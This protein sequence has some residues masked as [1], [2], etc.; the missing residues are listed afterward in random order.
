MCDSGS[1]RPEN[2]QQTARSPGLTC[3]RCG[4]VFA[5]PRQGK[6]WCSGSCRAAGSRTAKDHRRRRMETL[7][8]EL[9]RLVAEG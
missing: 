3:E 4:A 6:R 5:I 2:G 9:A 7:I 1:D 8:A